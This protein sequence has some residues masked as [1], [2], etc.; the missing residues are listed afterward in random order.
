[1]TLSVL[2]IARQ[3]AWEVRSVERAIARFREAAEARDPNELPAGRKALLE[4]VRPVIASMQDL[5]ARAATSS[6]EGGKP[7][8][9]EAPILAFSPEVLAVVAVSCALHVK[10]APGSR[11][12]QVLSRFSNRV[13]RS[14]VDQLDH[15]RFVAAQQEAQR[16]AIR[17]AKRDGVQ[18]AELR[19]IRED[20]LLR[21]FQRQNPKADRRAWRRFATRIEAARSAPWDEPT[22]HKIGGALAG[23]LT[24]GAPEW[25]E[26]VTLRQ[27]GIGGTQTV[28]YLL[29]TPHAVERMADATVRA[30]VARPMMLPMIVPPNPWRYA[31]RK[32]A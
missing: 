6:A 12:G 29:L 19:D 15:D 28:F 30:E 24:A 2:D 4:T 32:T 5:Q 23:A 18:E 14:L 27:S 16:E 25:F 9:W 13:A 20:A 22:R 3:S 1:M 31:E 7:G 17:L 10:E 8:D 11:I 26:L 21:M